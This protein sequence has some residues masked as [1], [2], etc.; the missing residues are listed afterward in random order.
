M[1]FVVVDVI[2]IVDIVDESSYVLVGN[3][4]IEFSW[5]W[6]SRGSW[7]H[8]QLHFRTFHMLHLHLRF[9][10][11]GAFL[12]SQSAPSGPFPLV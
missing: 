3:G 7:A 4:Q 5:L 6:H 1:I 9:V 10:K 11:R 2:G 12:V 8:A